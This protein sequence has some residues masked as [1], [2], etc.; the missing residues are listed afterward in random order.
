MAA[1]VVTGF[2]ATLL[3]EDRKTNRLP[4]PMYVKFAYPNSTKGKGVVE[5]VSISGCKVRSTTP[6]TSE[7]EI[8][9][10]FYPPGQGFAIEIEKAFVRWTGDGQFGVQ[11]SQMREEDQKRLQ[12]LIADLSSNQWTSHDFEPSLIDTSIENPRPLSR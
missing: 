1:F 5:D 8:H 2:T 10:Q 6:A 12:H 4:I 7:A 9:M 11:F 3:V